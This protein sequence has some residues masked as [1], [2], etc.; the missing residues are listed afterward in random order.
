[1]KTKTF[2]TQNVIKQQFPLQPIWNRWLMPAV[3]MLIFCLLMAGCSADKEEKTQSKPK[4]MPLVSVQAAQKANMVSY[5]DITGTIKANIFTNIKS[6]ADGI[7][8]SLSARE[9]QW[10]GKDKIIAVIDPIDRVSLIS[11]NQMKIEQ[12]E[13]K[14][15]KADPG[16]EEH[17]RLK[18][19]L[20][21]AKQNLEYARNMYKTVPVICPMNGVITE[22]YV[23][24]GSRVSVQD[25][26]LTITDMSS[27]VIK[28]RANEKY[29]QA[30]KQGKK[31]PVILNAYPNDTLQGKISLVYPQVDSETRNVKFDIQ[32]LGFN[33]KLLPGMMAA[34][35]IPVSQKNEVVAVPEHA[36]LTS[37]ENKNFIFVVDSKNIAHRRVIQKGMDY[38]N[39][40]EIIKGLQEGENIV[41]D[42]QERLKDGVKVKII[43]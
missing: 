10:V 38:N 17:Q 16:S 25:D 23:D 20:K 7:V 30:I 1:M 39:E 4:K 26:M 8:K 15:Q 43:K 28:A 35:K 33:Q 21:K 36:I 22:R 14:I 11:E 6:P 13:K 42:G 18:Q 32:V 34:I 29:F 12:I 40:V 3:S 41:V 31:L 5:V 27:L 9:N 24:K 19:E 2:Q 37:P